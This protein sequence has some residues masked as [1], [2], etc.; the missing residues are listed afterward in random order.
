MTVESLLKENAELRK[1]IAILTVK[2]QT[3]TQTNI[4]THKQ[5]INTNINRRK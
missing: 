3:Q 2:K 1:Q 5:N 4:N